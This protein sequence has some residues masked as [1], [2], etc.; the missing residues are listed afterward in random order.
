MSLL[1]SLSIFCYQLLLKL[2][3]L[4]HPKAKLLVNGRRETFEIIKKLPR[5]SNKRY[6]FHCASLG[7]YDMALPLIAACVA[8]DPKV[9][10]VV[11]FYSPS[12]MQ[13]FHKRGFVP[14]AV[15]YLP[16]DLPSTM[17]RLVQAV[18]ADRLY[19]L[20]YEFWPNLLRTAQK[21]KLDTFA[22]NTILR[23][24]QVYFK[25]YGGFFRKAL[26]HVAYFGV[27]NMATQELL[28]GVGIAAQQIEVLGDLRW[29]RVLEAK[30][31][32][33][34]NMIIE[35]F[36]KGSQLLI[37]GSSWPQ[38]ENLVAQLQTDLHLLIAPHD[39]SRAHLDTL[40]AQFPEALWY[41]QVEKNPA[42]FSP[43]AKIMILDT[44]G[45]LSS[46]YQYGS[47]AFVGGGFSGS[48]HNILE[49]LAYGLPVLFGP[50]HQKFPEAKQF[51]DLGF[52]QQI[53]S[54]KELDM[55]L[56]YFMDQQEKYQETI[57][58]KVF[59]MQ[60]KIPAKLVN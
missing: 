34:R 56:R 1:Y 46:A 20:K 44:I 52:A 13:H 42:S 30:Q 21:A 28:K 5:T 55:A 33:P 53:S 59:N 16:A 12:G 8:T 23:L 32:A 58:Q 22:V 57:T 41:S 14:H 45:Q 15:F 7:E 29:N 60:V 40:K 25:W 39:V 36:C 31:N 38:E 48:L 9:E 11:S 43:T 47:V 51:L 27:Q 35:R 4:W 19:L 17:R 54:A 37:L 49:P 24:S 2:A 3:A 10:I 26:Q 6:W 50:K 18:A